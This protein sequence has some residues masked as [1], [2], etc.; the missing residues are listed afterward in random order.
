MVLYTK[1]SIKKATTSLA[2]SLFRI[3][4]PEVGLYSLLCCRFVQGTDDVEVGL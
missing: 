2:L 4:E 1:E 3:P